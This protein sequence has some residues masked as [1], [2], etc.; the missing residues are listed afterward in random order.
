M[1]QLFKRSVDVVVGSKRITGLDCAFEIEKTL[2]AEPNKCSLK[3]WNLAEDTRAAFEQ[4]APRKRWM[5]KGIPTRIEAGYGNDRAPLWLGALRTV[6]P[7]LHG[8]DWVTSMDS[9]D[10]YLAFQNARVN[11]SYGPMTPV[12]TVL[13]ALVRQLGVGVGNLAQALAQLKVNG[14]GKLYPHGVVISGSVAQELSDFCLSAGLEWSIQDG[15]LQIL[16]RGQA[17]R[18][19]ALRVSSDTGMIGSPSVDVDGIATLKTL[20]IPGVRVGCMLVL[21]TARIKGTYRL[22]KATWSGDTSSDDWIIQMQA[23]KYPSLWDGPTNPN[24]T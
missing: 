15:V 16:D 5:T 4:L 8:P 23:R 6:P 22:M 14:V 19:K 20:L 2:N 10:G 3:I 21:D 12:D 18:G 9:G 1:T 11:L 24:G 13:Q 7:A 17:L